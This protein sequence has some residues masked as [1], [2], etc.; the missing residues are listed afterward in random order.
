MR[1]DDRLKH[2]CG[3]EGT[4]S[5]AVDAYYCARCNEWCEPRCDD[6]ECWYCADRPEKPIQEEE[7]QQ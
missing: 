7:C 3:D 5:D 1:E 6:P 4:Y 2:K